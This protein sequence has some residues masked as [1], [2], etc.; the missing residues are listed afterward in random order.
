MI[1]ELDIRGSAVLWCMTVNVATHAVLMS[2]PSD[3][4]PPIDWTTIPFPS[5]RWSLGEA[6]KRSDGDVEGLTNLIHT[7]VSNERTVAA[8]AMIHELSDNA[9]RRRVG[10]V[11][12]DVETKT[13]AAQY[14]ELG[15]ARGKHHA[16]QLVDDLIAAARANVPGKSDRSRD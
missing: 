4:L 15:I 6:R 11:L 8:H 5:D 13:L 12:L 2:T 14:V 16:K 9:D 1:E 7:L 10:D 3:P